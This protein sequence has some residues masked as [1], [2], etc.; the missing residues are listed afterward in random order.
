MESKVA[1]V[2]GP[3]DVAT[4]NHHGNRGSMNTYFVSC[5][6]PRVWIQ[7]NWS[8]DHPGADVLRRIISQELYPGRRDL[9][10]TVMLEANKRVIGNLIDESYQSQSGHIVV[11]VYAGG[12][13]YS[14]FVLNDKTTKREVVSQLDYLSKPIR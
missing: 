8:S 7:Q 11:R 14:V 3:V 6:R 5:L 9:F 10:A 1:P 4:M 2:I 13:R 12:D